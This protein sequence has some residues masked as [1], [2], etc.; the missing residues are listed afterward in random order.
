M[1][2]T[3]WLRNSVI[4]LVLAGSVA[5]AVDPAVDEDPVTDQGEALT[6]VPCSRV[7][8]DINNDGRVT[9]TDAVLANRIAAGLETATPGT[10]KFMAADLNRSGTVTVTDAVNLQRIAAGLPAPVNCLF[11]PITKIP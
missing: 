9:I 7:C 4:T 5:C 1:P 2:S 6:A 8:G 11:G 3:N 10:C